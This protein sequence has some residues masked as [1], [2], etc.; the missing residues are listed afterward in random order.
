M[1]HGIRGVAECQQSWFWAR[2]RGF[3][4]AAPSPAAHAFVPLVRQEHLAEGTQAVVASL[5]TWHGQCASARAT[6]QHSRHLP[7]Q[8]LVHR[9]WQQ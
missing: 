8:Q 5:M 9:A 6:L 3:F 7:D 1:Q 4:V 2:Q